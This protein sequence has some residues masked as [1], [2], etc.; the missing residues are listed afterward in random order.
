MLAV[1]GRRV[2]GR[3]RAGMCQR[4]RVLPVL[5][6]VDGCERA[7]TPR[8]LGKSQEGEVMSAAIDRF[9]KAATTLRRSWLNDGHELR[10]PSKTD[11]KNAKVEFD[12]A[13]ADL[14]P[15]KV[16]PEVVAAVRADKC[17]GCGRQSYQNCP[18]PPD[19][20]CLREHEFGLRN[21][22]EVVEYAGFKFEV[23]WEGVEAKL[24]AQAGQHAAAYKDKHRRAATQ[25]YNERLRHATYE[26]EVAASVHK[27]SVMDRL[28]IPHATK[29]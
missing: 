3:A 11:F 24:T 2:H 9:I 6:E 7:P 18:R 26:R 13:L 29:S 14:K 19:K 21:V 5:A 8:A 15:E 25:C 4:A 12:A 20:L 16:T 17:Q 23:T 28:G 27:M 1:E 10:E 22:T